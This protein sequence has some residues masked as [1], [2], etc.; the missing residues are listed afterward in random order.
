MRQ[1]RRR[2]RR[3]R[4]RLQNHSAITH[5]TPN[6][7]RG[8]RIPSNIP[9]T[10]TNLNATDSFCESGVVILVNPQGCAA[11]FVRPV[12]IGTAVLLEGLPGL[13][14][15]AARVVN[16]IRVEDNLWLLGLALHVPGNV[17]GV[18]N[19]PADWSIN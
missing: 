11:R 15:V 13:K 6:V 4:V 17:W 16:C 18:E 9:V 7:R 14:M 8:T 19:P 10:L 2:L 12:E 5:P 1:V 3:H